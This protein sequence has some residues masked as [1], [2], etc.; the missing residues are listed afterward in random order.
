MRLTVS[1]PTTTLSLNKLLRIHYRE[2]KRIK[3][4][5]EW[6]LLVAGACES[7][8][9]INGAKKRRVEIKAF[10]ARLLD[11]DNFYGGLK[12]LLDGLI[13]LELLH[14]DGPEFLELKAE[15]IKANKINQR[16]ELIIED[17]L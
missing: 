6:E 10:R 12:P 4:G 1:L 17:L 14:D 3:K 11:Q 7:Q 15:Q 16:V 5:F 13:E 2:R 9:K 8:Y